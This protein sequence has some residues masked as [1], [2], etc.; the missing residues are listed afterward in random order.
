MT[1]DQSPRGPRRRHVVGV[2]AGALALTGSVLVGVAVARQVPE[3]PTPRLE[4][5]TAA[6]APAP[7]AGNRA[8]AVP[9]PAPTGSATAV[10]GR[11]DSA[12]ASAVAERSAGLPRSRPTRVVIPALDVDSRD[13]VDLGLDAEG[14]M[15]VPDGA[16][17]VGWYTPSPTPGEIGPSVLAGHVSWKGERGTFFELG[18]LEPGDDVQVG[19]ADGSTAHFVVTRV[20]LYPKNEF[21]TLAVYGNTAGPELRLITCGGDFDESRSSFRD[22]VV[23]YA[24][25]VDDPDE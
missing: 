2:A 13:L 19:R 14:A 16:A 3:P 6:P 21:P 8:G 7:T 4:A 22:N 5:A 15:E 20:E 17:P 23:V 11:E 9:V 12:S 1:Q 18:R 10:P 25:L 24:E